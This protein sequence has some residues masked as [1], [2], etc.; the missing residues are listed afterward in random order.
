MRPGD[1][2]VAARVV[3][4]PARRNLAPAAPASGAARAPS[5]LVHPRLGAPASLERR[6]RI[7]PLRA[8]PALLALA[9]ALAA[10]CDARAR[11]PEDFAL[12][13][14]AVGDT[15]EPPRDP[16]YR[17]PVRRVASALAREDARS[18][19][20]GLV[21]LGDNF[22]PEGLPRREVKKRLR[23]NVVGP[24]CRFIELTPRGNGSLR[25]ACPEDEATHPLPI[26][27]VLGNHDY[28]RDESPELQ[29]EL[30]PE[31]VASWRMP[32][33]LVE[34]HELPGGVSLVL[35]DSNRVP[36]LRRREQRAV[37]RALARAR[38]PWRIVAAHHP[39]ARADEEHDVA[40]EKA[41]MRLLERARVP[42]HVFLAGHEHN[43]QVLLGEP[44]SPPLHVIS[45]AGSD[46]RSL[47]RRKS[48]ERMRRYGAE[49][50]GF[51]R[52]DVRA[53]PEPRLFVTMFEVRAF[54][55]PPGGRAAA[56]FELALD[57]R[58]RE[59]DPA[60]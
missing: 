3:D 14:L 53:G 32:R 60:D 5:R 30:V 50:L 16:A 22:Y 34:S 56:R 46:V 27:A 23:E 55:W 39:V 33:G 24:F 29:R 45:G 54:P 43:L 48:A 2:G 42:V 19:V 4:G 21:L 15:G 36:H 41:V 25:D 47:P 20:D 52:L 1:P 9:L 10:G 12:S 26:Y 31:Y 40:Y 58:V 17:D 38:G 57:G 51:A 7:A 11:A 8:A 28:E 35:L 13:L 49:S 18:S 59:V 44:P 37:E 6:V